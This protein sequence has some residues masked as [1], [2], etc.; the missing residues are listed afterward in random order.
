MA[1]V[2][3]GSD[4]TVK[5]NL[6]AN[7]S[8]Y[9]SKV[10]A[11]GKATKDFS[12]DAIKQAEKH[13]EAWNSVGRGML[14]GGALI[15]AA[16]GLAVKSYS[17]FDQQ[18]STV[19][20]V[21]G[22]TAQE[23]AKLSDAAI[24]AGQ[25]TKYSA[26][27]AAE[28]E[29]ELAKLGV[30]TADILG[31]ALRGSLDLAA[32]G[33]L[34]LA[35]AATY[36]GQ[37]M[38]I[39]NLQGKDVPHVADVLAAGAN[40]SAAD[41]KDLAQALQ[42]GGLVAAQTGL[43]LE[44]TAG[45]LAAF[46][47]NALNGS[48]AGTSFKTMLQRLNPQSKQ[49]ADLMDKLGLRAYDAQ[50]NFVGITAYAGKL[51]KALGRMSAEQR[52][53]A[54]Q[55]LF[56]SDAV[57]AANVL[58]KEGAAGI[59]K[60]IDGVNDQGAASRVAAIQMDNLNGDIEQ[61]RGSIETGLIKAGSAG[62][63]SLR[64]LAQGAT[65]A[66]N[67]ISGLPQPLLT[68]A[69]AAGALAAAT[70]L[71]GGA[72][73]KMTTAAA[74]ARAT[75]ISL[76]LTSEV[77]A[78]RLTTLAKGAA[79]VG[80]AY[81]AVSVAGSGLDEVLGVH[82]Q[83][84]DDAGKSLLA[85]AKG[86]RDAEGV[87]GQMSR[88]FKN[89]DDALRL[90]L[91]DSTWGKVK[92]FFSDAGT[93]TIVPTNKDDYVSFLKNVDAGLANLVQSGHAAEA[94]AIFNQLTVAAQKQGHSVTQLTDKLPNYQ[95]ALQG[96]SAASSE[97]AASSKEVAGVVNGV[98]VAAEDAGKAVDDYVE[99]LANAGLVQLSARDAARNYEQA[100]DD[101]SAA[102]RKNG[103]TLDIH[104]QKGR[105]NQAALDKVAKAA[106]TQAQAIYENTKA[107][108]GEGPA[109][110]AF[111]ASLLKSREGLEATA[112]KF[113]LSKVEAK[114]FADQLLQIPP[115]REV[116]IAVKG[117]SS[118]LEDAKRLRDALA[119]IKSKTITVGVR[120]GTANKLAQ[121]LGIP[122][123]A[124]GGSVQGPGT[125]T[126]DSVPAL[127]SRGEY[128]VKAAAV[129]KYGTTFFDQVNAMRFASG[130]FVGAASTPTV[131]APD[132]AVY[133]Q[134]PVDGEWVRAQA[135]VEIG[136][137]DRGQSRG[138]RSKAGSRY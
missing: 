85:Y 116:E 51:E 41:V 84:L 103:R 83:S 16:V 39:F 28:A 30:S 17:D 107:T 45:V 54:L 110:D 63:D 1:Y 4:R 97:T 115:K 48:D 47:D 72:I 69:T 15:G 98:A 133:V 12:R 82:N 134:S 59:Q 112:R 132:V 19:K 111:R 43:S 95:E 35:D 81:A 38:K 106:I 2:P 29:G 73:V 55:T 121:Q 86:G 138:Y 50:G 42:Q 135:R 124:T 93:L 102:I 66:V 76:G 71:A 52:N 119:G 24:N 18:L 129:D 131:G 87:T 104:T 5:V 74:S 6:K 37:A 26:S 67:I 44:D 64:A 109:Q 77:T 3:F 7:V 88:G 60:Y 36:A 92:E 20:A 101:A 99:A 127:L 46:S 78:A 108:Q 70:L 68:G 61:L 136:A 113:G 53:A 22:A 90:A 100:L 62:N 21:S 10:G 58:Y 120:V 8:D 9:I 33:N 123:L 27:Q 57:R 32:A 80:A 40:K 94:T 79:A 14:L 117:T 118:A 137:Y 75:L 130:G 49:A 11:A 96:A 122:G 34:N 23:M 56:G 91:D 65:H 125:K 25:A 128:V 31:G 105:D 13:K 114:K 89:L 126:S